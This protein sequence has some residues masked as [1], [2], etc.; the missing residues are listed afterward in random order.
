NLLFQIHYTPNGTA[1]KDVTT[2]GLIYAKTPVEHTVVTR[3]VLQTRLEIPPG[4]SNYEVKSS[5]TFNES[6][7]L[8]SFMPHMHLRGKD[9]VYKA[10][11][12]DG[13]SKILLS[14]PRY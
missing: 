5:F 6:A 3:P 2:V 4:D 14:V 8:Y 11:F 9:F 12:P 7:Q 13:S 1:T 10:V